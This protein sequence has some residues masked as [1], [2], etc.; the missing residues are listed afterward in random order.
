MKTGTYPQTRILTRSANQKP[1]VVEQTITVA[2]ARSTENILLWQ[3]YLPDN[4][5]DTMIKMGWDQ[6][7]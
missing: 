5:V 2:T 1:S 3:T 7:A 4:C 6:T